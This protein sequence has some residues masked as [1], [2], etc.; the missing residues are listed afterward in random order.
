MS[1][2]PVQKGS[3]DLRHCGS[4]HL[5]W[6]CQ[7]TVRPSVHVINKLW[8]KIKTEGQIPGT[9]IEERLVANDMLKFGNNTANDVYTL[10]CKEKVIKIHPAR[11]PSA[12][13]AFL[14]C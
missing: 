6:S 14:N 9:V 3:H 13:P 10:R 11:F 8:D 12:L 1:V 4:A 7:E 5:T 2:L